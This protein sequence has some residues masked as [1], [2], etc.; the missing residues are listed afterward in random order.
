MHAHKYEAKVEDCAVCSTP[1]FVQYSVGT[2]IGVRCLISEGL[3]VT[4]NARWWAAVAPRLN[5]KPYTERGQHSLRPAIYCRERYVQA[6]ERYL[7]TPQFRDAGWT[8]HRQNSFTLPIRPPP[9]SAV[10]FAFWYVHDGPAV[11]MM[12]Y[13]N[14]AGNGSIF[15]YTAR[16]A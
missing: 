14:I 15:I 12:T 16:A 6:G 2:R 5:F 3:S 9:A 7:N 10:F 8:E 11:C 1:C 4:I 13:I